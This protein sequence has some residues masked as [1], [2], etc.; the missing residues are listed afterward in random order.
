MPVAPDPDAFIGDADIGANLSKH[1]ER[2]LKKIGL[3]VLQQHVAAC[4]R[5]AH[6]VGSSLYAI[7][8]HC[9]M[10]PVQT[11]HALNFDRRRPGTRDARAHFVEAIRQIDDL[12]LASCIPD[13][14]RT[15]CE[16]RRH[17]RRMRATDRHLGKINLAA[18]EAA[19]RGL[20]HGIAIID[21]DRR[22]KSLQ[23]H[24]QEIDRTCP[25]GAA[26]RQGHLSLAHAGNQRRDHPE[27]G[28]HCRDELVGCGGVHDGPRREPY[29]RAAQ[30]A[31]PVALSGDSDIDA[32]I[33]ENPPQIR[34]VAQSW[35]VDQRQIVFRQQ[36]G[37][38]QR[39]RRVPS[40]PKSGSFR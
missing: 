38:H 22:A 21:L 6:G 7:R 35:D 4:H 37:D 33:A 8:H 36:A 26:A 3:D 32:M 10:R 39:Q 18:G 12:R 24:Q 19:S 25:Y 11:G 30:W 23:R 20:C 14:R 27:T 40:H 29:G 31:L 1:V 9:M 34:D 28:T 13:D 17:Q 15:R 16:A 2:G 5:R